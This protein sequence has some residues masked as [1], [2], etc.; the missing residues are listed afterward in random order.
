MIGVTSYHDSSRR[1]AGKLSL[2]TS[3]RSWSQR[4]G[5][6]DVSGASGEAWVYLRV[7]D[8]LMQNVVNGLDVAKNKAHV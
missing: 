2:R 1:R 5:M 6:T 7:A 4:F 8:A 3:A